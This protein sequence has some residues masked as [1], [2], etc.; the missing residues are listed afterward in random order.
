VILTRRNRPIGILVDYEEYERMEK[1]IGAF[2]DQVLGQLAKER[3]SRKGRKTID[4]E[5]AERRVG[6][7]SLP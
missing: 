2:E 1:M 7:N 4:L 5:E 3:A 6:I